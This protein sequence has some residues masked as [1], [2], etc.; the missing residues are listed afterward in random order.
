MQETET[1]LEVVKLHTGKYRVLTF[2]FNNIHSPP[3][4]GD[5]R[6][7]AIEK[8]LAWKKEKYDGEQ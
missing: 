2:D 6:E 1:S 7:D 3:P 5:T 4:E 8:Y